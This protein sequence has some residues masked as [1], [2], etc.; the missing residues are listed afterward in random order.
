V[1]QFIERMGANLEYPGKLT[2]KELSD[3]V[4]QTYNDDCALCDV[5]R[6]LAYC[7]F[8]DESGG[9]GINTSA[10][11]QPHRFILSLWYEGDM[12]CFEIKDDWRD[13]C[14]SGCRLPDAYLFPLQ[15]T[16]SQEQIDGCGHGIEVDGTSANL[17][18][19]KQWLAAC[20]DSHKSNLSRCTPQ[21]ISDT[22]APMLRVIDCRTRV[23]RALSPTEPYICLS[24]VW[25]GV[26]GYNSKNN[27]LLPT[28]LP[29]TIEDAIHVANFLEIPQLWV[30]QYCIDQHDAPSRDATIQR[31][32]E[33]YSSASLTIVAA[34]SNNAHTGLPGIR[35]TIRRQR[36]LI[37]TRY[38][39]F[40]TC[41]NPQKQLEATS[42][43]SR[44]W[45]YQEGLLSRRRLVFLDEQI[46]FQCDAKLYMECLDYGIALRQHDLGFAF[47]FRCFP[48]LSHPRA[49]KS[50]I[51][52]RL[53]EYYPRR[54]SYPTDSL[55]AFE[56]II[57]AYPNGRHCRLYHH[58][59]HFYGIT[60]EFAPS[61]SPISFIT[62]FL[63]GLSWSMK[64]SAP[65]HHPD[66]ADLDS[67]AHLPSW[68]WA[69][70]KAVHPYMPNNLK[71][72]LYTSFETCRVDRIELIVTHKSLGEMKLEDI[73]EIAFPTDYK[74]F[75]PMIDITTHA[76]HVQ[77]DDKPILVE[78]SP[79][80]AP[81]ARLSLDEE[82]IFEERKIVILWI[83][84]NVR[85]RTSRFGST[86]QTAIFLL[87]VANQGQINYRRIGLWE[88]I[89]PSSEPISFTGIKD[90]TLA[91]PPPGFSVEYW[92]WEKVRL[93]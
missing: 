80:R 89:I 82:T 40:I 83:G 57:N 19:A 4:P 52:V 23:I 26:A 12:S 18:R 66:K 24:Y 63:V 9:T 27:S 62:S 29:K 36:P 33:V 3:F 2:R 73:A 21:S 16:S 30:D 50:E 65:F 41:R 58:P 31:M 75:L 38:H 90:A 45:T 6:S 55:A 81:L 8:Q 92:G 79:R 47:A 59:K 34:S 1:V 44:G 56:G 72:M 43:S 17:I 85:F 86:T 71:P 7:K 46:F 76:F 54:L 53:R 61:N 64:T 74:A 35:G 68:T 91:S 11:K 60:L 77:L 22:M 39:R 10:S 37:N 67:V 78:D 5:F 20:C 15:G 49:T 84:L 93:V 88:V 42:W 32:N 14:P 69:W 28:D 70:P 51:C 13:P 25:G 87:C 48:A